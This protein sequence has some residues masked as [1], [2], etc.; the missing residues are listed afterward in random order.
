M[1]YP[2]PAGS[3]PVSRVTLCT[4]RGLKISPKLVTASGQEDIVDAILDAASILTDLDMNLALALTVGV[5]AYAG[6]P[7]DNLRERRV[8]PWEPMNRFAIKL[9]C[10]A[11][12]LW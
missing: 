5:V 2:I 12:G 10:G 6:R 4:K 7:L 9:I 3:T 11:A 8:R 1:R